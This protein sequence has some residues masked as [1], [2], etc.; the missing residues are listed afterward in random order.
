M[1]NDKFLTVD[2]LSGYIKIPK[3]TIYMLLSK[4]RIPGAKVG[5]QW[6]FNKDSIDK[7]MEE[8]EHFYTEQKNRRSTDNITQE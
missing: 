7:W 3:P 5:R 2:E 4:R 8:K 6:R 1:D